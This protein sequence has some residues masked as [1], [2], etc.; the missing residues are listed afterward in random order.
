MNARNGNVAHDDRE[1][2]ARSFVRPAQVR[3]KLIKKKKI[4]KNHAANAISKS[5]R[6]RGK[7]K[8]GET[9]RFNTIAVPTARQGGR[10]RRHY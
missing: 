8:N 1:M 9:M 7:V 10:S 4:Q 6:I 3:Y 5:R 2:T